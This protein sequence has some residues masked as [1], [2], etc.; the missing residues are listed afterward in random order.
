MSDLYRIIPE[1]LVV[2]SYSNIPLVRM[3]GSSHTRLWIK[4]RRIFDTI[5]SVCVLLLIS[6]LLLVIV[7]IIKLTSRGPIIYKQQRIGLNGKV[8]TFYK[9]RTMFV[10]SDNDDKRSGLMEDYIKGTNKEGNEVKKVVDNFQ[11]TL[12]GKILRK[13]SLDEVPQ[14][15][16][17]L[18]GDLAV[19]GPRPC[20][21][22][23]FVHYDNWQKKRNEVLPGITGL[24]QV[25]GRSEVAHN[26]MIVMDL[27]YIRNASPWFDLSLIFKTILIMING[28]GGG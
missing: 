25:A 12:I 1:K 23:E 11:L 24:W 28:K 10:G 13:T 7:L 27:Y 22:Y 19:V 20:L 26:E 8:F 3:N 17:V 2:E 9:F 21:P 16:N 5:F 15:F 14:F 4:Y 6:P 18:K